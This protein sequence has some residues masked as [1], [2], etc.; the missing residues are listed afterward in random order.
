MTFGRLTSKWRIFKRNLQHTPE[1]CTLLIQCACILHNY[2]IDCDFGGHIS[3]IVEEDNTDNSE[4]DDDDINFLP[5]MD[6][7]IFPWDVATM[8]TCRREYILNEI[9]LYGLQ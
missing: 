1:N 7:I 3:N 6:E 4:D 8:D 9:M 5:A 2:I